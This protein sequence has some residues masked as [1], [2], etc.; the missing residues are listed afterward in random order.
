MRMAMRM[1]TLSAYCNSSGSPPWMSSLSLL[2]S[3]SCCCHHTPHRKGVPFLPIPRQHQLQFGKHPSHVGA[4]ARRECER[5]PGAAAVPDPPLGTTTV[6]T[7]TALRSHPL[8]VMPRIQARTGALAWVIPVTVRPGCLRWRRH[9]PRRQQ[10]HQ[11]H[12]AFPTSLLLPPFTVHP[13]SIAQLARTL[14]P[15]KTHVLRSAVQAIYATGTPAAQI[16]SLTLH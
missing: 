5:Q 7:M 9:C 15:F 2:S 6:R 11:G 12:S 4:L 16:M 3:M 1:Q 8:P 13:M 14:L 10:W